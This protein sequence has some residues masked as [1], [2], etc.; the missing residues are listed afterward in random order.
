MP[1]PAPTAGTR[2][3]SPASATAGRRSASRS[4][5]GTGTDPILKERLFGL[6]GQEGNHGEDVKE[7]YWY[8]DTT[9]THSYMKMLYKY[10]QRPYP[11]A[12]LLRREPCSAARRNREYE[13]L[14]TGAFEQD[15]YFDVLVEYAKADAE[16][17]LVRIT[18]ANRGPEAAHLHLLPTL[19]FRNT[20]TWGRGDASRRSRRCAP[21]PARALGAA[22]EHH[23][24]GSFSLRLR[25]RAGAPLHRERDQR[26]AALRTPNE[27]ALT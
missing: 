13:L 4:R 24:D 15:R 21:R 5:C 26:P 6:T 12:E 1:A 25:R 27:L 10:P 20:W 8:L 2:T 11:Y 18:V 22:H 9:P 7:L 16:D 17:V 14:D 3:A 23:V 19:W